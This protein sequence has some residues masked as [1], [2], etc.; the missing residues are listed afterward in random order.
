MICGVQGMR[1]Q[2]KEFQ[3]GKPEGGGYVYMAEASGTATGGTSLI[4]KL[5]GNARVVIQNYDPAASTFGISLANAPQTQRTISGEKAP[6]EFFAV[7]SNGETADPSWRN[8]VV[9]SEVRDDDNNL[10]KQHV[11]HHL[12]D[13]LGNLIV[14][15]AAPGRDD[16][17]HDSAGDDVLERVGGD[18]NWVLAGSGRDF[19][20]SCTRRKK[21]LSALAK[22]SR[23]RHLAANDDGRRAA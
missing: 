19:V 16:S 13:D 8:V 10:I 2:T 12:A 21:A 18:D 9:E 14:G 1:E 7:L 17:L 4:L 11:N 22:N 5:P 23:Q 6:Q 20:E 15:G 3:I